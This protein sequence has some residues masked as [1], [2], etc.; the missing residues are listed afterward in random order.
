M[1]KGTAFLVIGHANWGK[2]KTLKALTEGNV[3]I[4]HKM[5]KEKIFFIRRMSN[6]D[7]SEK[8]K[9]F[10]LALDQKYDEN[11]IVSFCPNIDNR[12]KDTIFILKNLESKY[13]LHS[14]ILKHQY[15]SNSIISSDEID[16]VNTYSKDILI[17][18]KVNAESEERAQA[19]KKYI[20]SNL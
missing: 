5:F 10:T 14:F 13:E 8:Y 18:T 16:L 4:K 2:S 3:H 19:L 20:D 1:S 17:Y 15:G 12:I 11:I 6:D 7:L 9:I